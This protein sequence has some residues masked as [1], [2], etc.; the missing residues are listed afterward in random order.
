V[1]RQRRDW[2]LA[3]A[4]SSRHRLFRRHESPKT[5]PSHHRAISGTWVELVETNRA[6]FRAALPLPALSRRVEFIETSSKGPLA[7]VGLHS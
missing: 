3:E 4:A 7:G 6:G 2:R 1:Q 5:T